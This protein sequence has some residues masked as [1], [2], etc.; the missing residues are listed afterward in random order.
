MP[1]YRSAV[2]NGLFSFHNKK[3]VLHKTKKISIFLL[4]NIL[5]CLSATV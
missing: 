4:E 2:S 5:L 1:V 3:E